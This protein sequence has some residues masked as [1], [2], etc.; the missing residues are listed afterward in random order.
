MA[1]Y[2][3]VISPSLTGRAGVGP[4]LHARLSTE[5]GCYG[6]EDGN[7]DVEDLAPSCVVIEC[8]HS[9]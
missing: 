6:R 9:G 8:S 7:Y 2:S 3:A 1:T 5:R 4:L